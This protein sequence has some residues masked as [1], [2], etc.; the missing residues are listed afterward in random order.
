MERKPTGRMYDS[1]MEYPLE[2][3]KENARRSAMNSES[4]S[5]ANGQSARVQA[6]K[7]GPQP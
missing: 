6:S 2:P 3:I 1:Y 7:T 5:S 4:Q